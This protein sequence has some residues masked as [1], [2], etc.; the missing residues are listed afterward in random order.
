MSD[1]ENKV[2][3]SVHGESEATYVC[4]Y[5]LKGETLGFHYGY[6]PECPDSLYHDL[7]F[8]LNYKAQNN[9][10]VRPVSS[11]DNVR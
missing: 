9:S 10:L 2:Q 3:C 6:D 7:E 11:D 5:L 1:S 4:Q 8:L